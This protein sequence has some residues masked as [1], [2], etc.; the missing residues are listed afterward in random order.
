LTGAKVVTGSVTEI[1]S[2]ENTVVVALED[3]EKLEIAYDYLVVGL[4]AVP[5]L[6]PIP[7]LAENAI[8]FKQ[9]EE[10]TAV[11]D[12][13]LANL[14]EAATTKDPGSASACSPSPS[15]AA[16]SPAAKRWP[17]PRTWSATRCATTPTST[18]RT[19]ASCWS[20][21]HRSSSPSSPR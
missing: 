3:D 8:G 20:T 13:V 9:V 19:S 2:A 6:L 1:R 10:A 14:A 16:A 15:S 4:G 21:A 18:P 5:R 7:G 17:S 12:R 11:R